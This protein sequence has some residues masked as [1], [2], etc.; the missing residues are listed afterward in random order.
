[1]HARDIDAELVDADGFPVMTARSGDAIDEALQKEMIEW[2]TA[3][4]VPRQACSD[5][6]WRAVTMAS[7]VVGEL[8]SRAACDLIPAEG[9]PPMLQLCPIL[10]PNGRVDQRRAACMWFRHTVAQF[11]WPPACIVLVEENAGDAVRRNSGG[12]GRTPRTVRPLSRSS[13]PVRP[14]SVRTQ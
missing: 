13:L 11:G 2:W 4:G 9:T 5:E 1:M 10:P 12:W 6:Q 7:A 8:A 14:T 3:N